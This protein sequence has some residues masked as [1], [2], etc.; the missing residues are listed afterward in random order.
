[1]NSLAQYCRL[2]WW[3]LP[4]FC[5]MVMLHMQ[6]GGG[7]AMQRAFDHCVV[8]WTKRMEHILSVAF[9]AMYRRARSN[10]KEAS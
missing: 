6:K 5:A 1:V 4:V 2:S 9:T 8:W 10:Q 7:L 3:N